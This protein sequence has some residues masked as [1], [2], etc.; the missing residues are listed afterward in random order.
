MI[1]NVEQ[2]VDEAGEPANT[3]SVSE[4]VSVSEG[5][6]DQPVQSVAAGGTAS[7]IPFSH[8][9]PAWF[10]DRGPSA[11]QYLLKLGLTAFLPSMML[12]GL[13]V[14][15]RIIAGAPIEGLGPDLSD[16]PP[17][18]GFLLVVVFAPVFETLILSL[19]IGFISLFTRRPMAIAC[20]SA[21]AWGALHALSFKVQGVVVTWPFF[22]FSCAYLAWRP[23]GWSK[24]YGMAMGLHMF[25]NF[26]PGLLLSLH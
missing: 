1:D 7:A 26:L 19:G 20:I 16:V 15:V 12:G 8:W 21:V 6:P 23:L 2:P 18:R 5:A 11:W 17:L 22:V 25:Q 13:I 14:A 10:F 4:S 3:T 24:A 9:A